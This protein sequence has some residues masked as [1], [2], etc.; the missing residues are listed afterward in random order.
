MLLP[1]QA[2]AFGQ[3]TQSFLL[4]T[5]G[6]LKRVPNDSGRQDALGRRLAEL[7]FRWPLLDR[8]FRDGFRR[9]E[10]FLARLF[11]AAASPRWLPTAG[12]K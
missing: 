3:P 2:T 8:L 10:R 11:T 6:L 9:P 1:V 12:V 5:V 7:H 4:V